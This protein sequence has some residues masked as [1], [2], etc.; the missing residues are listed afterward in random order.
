MSWAQSYLEAFQKLPLQ[1]PLRPGT[2]VAN[3]WWCQL[4]AERAT[5]LSQTQV[6]I[7][8]SLGQTLGGEERE[9]GSHPRKVTQA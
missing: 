1:G 5:S 2:W 3:R 7:I 6:Q 9:L 8:L 4:G